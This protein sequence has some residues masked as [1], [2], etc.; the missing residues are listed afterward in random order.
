MN[1]I[2]ESKLDKVL[3]L[4]AWIIF[5][6]GVLWE[7]LDWFEWLRTHSAG[8][9]ITLL[10]IWGISLQLRGEAS[11][12]KIVHIS[13]CAS[14]FI[15]GILAEVIGVAS[16]LVFGDYLY[17]NLL[18]PTIGRVP[19]AIGSAWIMMTLFSLA[20]FNSLPIG[21]RLF[22]AA[23]MATLFDAL[24]EPAAVQLGYWKWA[25]GHIPFQNY[26][27]WF[28]LAF[29]FSVLLSYSPLSRKNPTWMLTHILLIQVVYFILVL[30]V[31]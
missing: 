16:G 18:G 10:T 29:V 23:T 30:T 3:L 24:M 27:A 26:F 5:P 12:K 15:L 8:P 20:S 14:V 7:Y 28:V 22:A 21:I 25:N 19:I 31:L 6:A 2:P 11:K 13:I 17:G 9:L 4:L 1:L